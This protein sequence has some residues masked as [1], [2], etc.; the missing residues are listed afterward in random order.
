MVNF[1]ENLHFKLVTCV[2]LTGNEISPEI[3]RHRE[4]YLLRRCLQTE[5]DLRNGG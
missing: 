5:G 2:L 3:W 1:K 4:N